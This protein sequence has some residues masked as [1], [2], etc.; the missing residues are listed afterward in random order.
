ME[1]GD[2]LVK[3]ATIAVAALVAA[4]SAA[5]LADAKEQKQK[6][7]DPNPFASYGP[8]MVSTAENKLAVNWSKEN[9]AKIAAATDDAVLAGFVADDAAADALLSRI[10]PAYTSDPLVLTQIAAVTQYVMRPGSWWDWLLFW[11][12][13]VTSQRATW[14][15]ALERRAAMPGSAYVHTFCEQQLYLCR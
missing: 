6:Y 2:V 5:A 15:S 3:I 13:S 12:P 7:V 11:E 10:G 9:D 1:K 4:V 14:V 8:A